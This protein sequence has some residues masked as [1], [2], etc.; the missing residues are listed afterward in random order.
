VIKLIRL[1]DR[2][3]HGQVAIV[4]LKQLNIKTLIVC[5]DSDAASKPATAALKMAAPPGCKTFVYSEDQTVKM[6][7]DPRAANLDCAVIVVDMQGVYRICKAVPNLVERVNF[8]NYGRLNMKPGES[9]AD[10]VQLS[11]NVHITQA[12]RQQL[13]EL[14]EMGIK[15]DA[16]LL[17][18]M[19]MV[20]VEDKIK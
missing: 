13:R 8:G 17:P 4:W 5:S 11:D 15:M 12:E 19:P 20:E 3:I 6:L 9:L 1:D 14:L 10:K 2:R 18:Y 16:Q 7:S